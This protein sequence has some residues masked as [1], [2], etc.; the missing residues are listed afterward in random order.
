VIEIYL[1]LGAWNL[2]LSFS[3]LSFSINNKF[4]RGQ[5]LQPHGAKRVEFGGAD[6][7]LCTQ[8]QL[9]SVIESCRG[10]DQDTGGVN[11]F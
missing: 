3:D 9:E 2:V 1:E 10:I 6:S 8:A 11:F 4:S 7:D 5:F